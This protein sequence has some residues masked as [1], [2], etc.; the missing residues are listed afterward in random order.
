MKSVFRLIIFFLLILPCLAQADDSRDPFIP[1][2]N[3]KGIMRTKFQKPRMEEINIKINLSGISK[4][5]NT[6]Y[7]IIEGELLKEGDN[8]KEFK[9]EKIEDNRVILSFGEKLFEILLETEKKL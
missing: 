1:L 5:G 7:A 2:V 6:F 8:F 3:E 9:I 4:I